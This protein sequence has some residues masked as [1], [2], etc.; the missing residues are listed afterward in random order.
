MAS[1]YQYP[2]V[3][4]E[5]I[6]GPQSIQGVSTSTTGMVGVTERSMRTARSIHPASRM[7]MMARSTVPPTRPAMGRRPVG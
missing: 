3:Y 5:E 6:P 4:I 2:G 7:P 1:T